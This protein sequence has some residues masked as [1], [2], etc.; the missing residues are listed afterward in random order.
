[1][2]QIYPEWAALVGV[3][4]GFGLSELSQFIRYRHR[5][6]RLKTIVEEELKSIRCQIDQKL[7]I[8][9]KAQ[10]R[11]G[12]KQILSTRSVRALTTG[13]ASALRELYGHLGDRER[14]CLHVIYEYLRV[15]DDTMDQ[16]ETDIMAA[17]KEEI[18]P[19]PFSAYAD[20][21]RDLQT[22]YENAK[23]LIDSYLERRPIDV[24]QVATER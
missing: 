7:D 5:I 1:M 13:Y 20:R 8:L 14:N 24:F 16:F 19:D 2:P 4:L 3:V 11:L 17:I 23:R 15:G 12:K 9:S 18:L 21:F 6:C 22:N 10:E